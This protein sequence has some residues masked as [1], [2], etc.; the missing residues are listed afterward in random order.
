MGRA[1]KG[2]SPPPNPTLRVHRLWQAITLNGG[3]GGVES[4][5]HS[6]SH[7]G[8]SQEVSEPSDQMRQTCASRPG[9][10]EPDLVP[11]LRWPLGWREG[12]A[13][14]LKPQVGRGESRAHIC[15]ARSCPALTRPSLIGVSCARR[16]RRAL[17]G[18]PVG[19]GGPAAVAGLETAGAARRARV[20]GAVEVRG[21]RSGAPRCV[22]PWGDLGIAWGSGKPLWAGYSWLA[23]LQ[24]G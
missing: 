13:W 10:S 15:P 22:S 12:N 2:A 11:S 6:N 1:R 20:Q 17:S 3:W 14:P 8:K 21:H 5:S 7:V 4:N 18:S 24:E 9:G 23:L 19:V 16:G